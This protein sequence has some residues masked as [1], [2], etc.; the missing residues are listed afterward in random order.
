[1]TLM[2][3]FE[4]RYI[5][6]TE[7]GCW[8]WIG[9]TGHFG[10]GIMPLGARGKR[11][12]AHRVSWELFRGQI[13]PGMNVCHHCDVP[14]CVNP[15][16]LFLGTQKDNLQDCGRKGRTAAQI[17]PGIRRGVK[18]G[19]VRLTLEQVDYI[20]ATY[21]DGRG[22][23]DEHGQRG[24][25]PEGKCTGKELAKQLGVNYRTVLDVV[26]GHQWSHYP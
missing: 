12:S 5:P 1:M 2:D 15:L 26:N 14:C 17:Y 24:I 22:H 3:K 23:F 25:L 21:F 7:S 9:R 10:Y 19:N 4:A 11:A 20:R 13:P 6:V 16:H 8:L 18:N